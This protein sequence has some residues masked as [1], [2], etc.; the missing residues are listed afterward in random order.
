MPKRPSGGA[1]ALL[2]TLQRR[3][4]RLGMPYAVLARR[5]G[6]SEPT[7]KRMLQGADGKMASVAQ[8]A[9]A[10]GMEL[11]LTAKTSVMQ[12]QEAQA[13]RKAEQLVAMVQGTS[14]LEAQAVQSSTLE[15][16]TRRTEHELMAGSKRRLWAE[17]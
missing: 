12:M 15:D 2:K 6:V 3:R 9:A 13:R 8:V 5:S 11:N 1:R 17:S 7:L 10:L 16:L 4:R 14:A